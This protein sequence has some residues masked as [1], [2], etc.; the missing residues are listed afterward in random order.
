MNRLFAEILILSK[1]I[2]S[3][4]LKNKEVRDLNEADYFREE[5]RN[6]IRNQLSN[7]D[8]VQSRKALI[9]QIDRKNDFKRVRSKINH[10][11]Q[12]KI[13]H[14]AAAA[15]VILFFVASEL[16]QGFLN[17]D[18]NPARKI[19]ISIE[20]PT[21]EAG[22]NKAFL[23]LEDGEIIEL[24]EKNAFQNDY[25]KSSGDELVVLPKEHG[26][27]GSFN[28]LNIPRGGQFH[29]VLSDGTNVWLNSETLLKFPKTF[30]PGQDR[31]VELIYGEAY[32]DV[33]P[34]ELHGGSPFKV[35]NV[36]QSVE[37]LG[38]EFNIKAYPDDTTELTT[39]VEGKVNV[40][41]GNSG[42][43]LRP[44]EQSI[45]DLENL[46][47]SVVQVDA[48]SESSWKRGLFSFRGKPLKEIMKVV[49]RWYDVDVE[50]QNSELETIPFRGVLGKNQNIEELL[51]TIKSLSIIDDYEV[52][53][54]KI[55]LK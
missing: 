16:L 34:S 14:Y 32:F 12:I 17:L 51:S 8:E 42:K 30:T 36:N 11:K 15:A 45:L 37:V 21:I 13:W 31:V 3:D 24:D 54:R 52:R 9:R 33:T 50:F 46:K 55:I 23:V 4:L 22:S 47:M 40:E 44:N 43:I 5:D 1:R 2:A 48:L 10:P 7:K 28:S 35:I 25:L 26:S 39:L 49:S 6:Y 19:S 29:L 41:H 20:K 27:I 38:T 18:N 53:N